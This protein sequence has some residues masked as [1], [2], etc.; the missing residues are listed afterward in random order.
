M[1]AHR[2]LVFYVA[3]REPRLDWL[4][5]EIRLLVNESIRV[6]VKEGRAHGDEPSGVELGA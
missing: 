1:L 5:S 3:W 2:S 6:A 4:L